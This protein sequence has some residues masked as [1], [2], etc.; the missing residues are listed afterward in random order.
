MLVYSS[1]IAR[2]KP[3]SFTGNSVYQYR[4]KSGLAP[5]KIL[6]NV[7]GNLLEVAFH[8]PDFSFLVDGT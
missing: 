6:K 8:Y 3:L 1:A 2:S 7:R 4:S 5:C